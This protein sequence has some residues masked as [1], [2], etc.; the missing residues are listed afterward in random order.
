VDYLGEIITIH[1][2][3]GRLVSFCIQQQMGD[4]L[5]TILSPMQDT[6]SRSTKTAPPYFFNSRS[7]PTLIRF[8]A[9]SAP[10]SAPAPLI[11]S[12]HTTY[13][14]WRDFFSLYFFSFPSLV[15]SNFLQVVDLS[16][17]DD[18][19]SRSRVRLHWDG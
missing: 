16:Q 6:C 3:H 5:A 10:F 1:L 12:A 13:L 7:A 11:C 14:I 18:I 4:K 2:C 8:S 17:P 15:K 19:P 9:R